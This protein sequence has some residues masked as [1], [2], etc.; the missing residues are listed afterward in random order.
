MSDELLR[1]GIWLW[2]R[3]PNAFRYA[4][5]RLKSSP[6][7]IGAMALVTDDT[8]RILFVRQSYRDGWTL[9][10][11]M[12]ARGE[13]VVTCALRETMEEVGLHVVAVGEPSVAIVTRRRRIETVTPCRLAP[14]VDPESA[15]P[16]SPEIAEVRWCPPDAMPSL[17]SS[18]STALLAHARRTQVSGGA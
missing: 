4:A 10:G 1:A 2:E 14:G 8:E 15:R 18:A 6:Y 9:P 13:D 17:Q 11:G 5:I 3:S 12:T 7:R 16:T